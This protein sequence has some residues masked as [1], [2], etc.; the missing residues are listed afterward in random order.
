[1][2][3]QLSTGL[4]GSSSTYRIPDPLQH[5]LFWL[6]AVSSQFAGGAGLAFFPLPVVERCFPCSTPTA[7]PAAAGPPPPLCWMPRLCR[8]VSGWKDEGSV[9]VAHWRSL[10]PRRFGSSS[11]DEAGLRAPCLVRAGWEAGS[12]RD[13][14]GCTL[15]CPVFCCSSLC[16]RR[17]S[18]V[19]KGVS[20]PPSVKQSHGSPLCKVPGMRKC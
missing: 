8:R 13:L 5:W 11:A 2:F 3:L 15:A 4:G 14:Q 10:S 16:D 9:P 18:G 1:M 20:V 7:A 12:L 17:S 19:A 6:S